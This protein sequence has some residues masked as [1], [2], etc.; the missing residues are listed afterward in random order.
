MLGLPR[1]PDTTRPRNGLL[2]ELLVEAPGQ[3]GM[4]G[5]IKGKV[6][7]HEACV[8]PDSD[9]GIQVPADSKDGISCLATHFEQGHWLSRQAAGSPLPIWFLESQPGLLNQDISAHVAHPLAL[10]GP[11]SHAIGLE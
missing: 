3:K 7:H 1:F 6:G 4:E 8:A 9:S 10:G 5:T 2:E 11:L